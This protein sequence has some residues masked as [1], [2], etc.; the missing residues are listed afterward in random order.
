MWEARQSRIRLLSAL[1]GKGVMIFMNAQKQSDEV[2]HAI[3]DTLCTSQDAAAREAGR[4]WKWAL[5]QVAKT[6]RW[7]LRIQEP[8]TQ[9]SL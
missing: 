6:D 8:E 1:R 2:V 3:V 4:I 5:E 9:R 7:W